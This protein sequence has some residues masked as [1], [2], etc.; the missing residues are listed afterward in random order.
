[1]IMVKKTDS[2]GMKVL[3]FNLFL[4]LLLTTILS[5]FDLIS[6][7]NII[8]PHIQ[9]SALFLSLFLWIYFSFNIPGP[10]W[11]KRK[12]W[13]YVFP[14]VFVVLLFLLILYPY[15]S[16]EIDLVKLFILIFFFGLLSF[17]FHKE[18]ISTTLKHED[19]KEVHAQ[20]ELE[21][22][23]INKFRVLNDIPLIGYVIRKI[24][25]Q[26]FT[27][28]L[29]I[30][31]F[32]VYGSFLVLN[33]L[34]S[35]DIYHDEQWELQ[36][37]HSL[38]NG[39][40]FRLWNYITSSP[41][42]KINN[43]IILSSLS[44]M[45]TKLF[46]FNNFS[47]RLPSAIFGILNILLVFIAFRMYTNKRIG[48]ITSLGFLL[49]L[50]A[51]YLARFFRAYTIALFFYLLSFIFLSLFINELKNKKIRMSQSI[52][53]ITLGIVSLIISI[54]ER[55]L[56]K[57]LLIL[58][59]L[60]FL[61][62]ILTNLDMFRAR[63]GKTKL[64]FALGSLILLI[65]LLTRIEV[66]DI[67]LIM[68]QVSE[69]ISLSKLE[70]PTN[71]YYYYLFEKYIKSSF[72]FYFLVFVGFFFLSFDLLSKKCQSS[73][74]MIL[75]IFTVIPMIFMIY[76]LNRY[77]DPRYIYFLIPFVYSFFGSGL[78][79]LIV[80]F[81]PRRSDLFKSILILI[82]SLTF[83]FYLVLPMQDIPF[84]SLKS[85]S[86]WSGEEPREYWHH[87][88][89]VPEYTKA[90]SYLNNVQKS[91]DV[92]VII[93][94][95]YNLEVTPGVSYYNLNPWI[96]TKN[97]TSYEIYNLSSWDDLNTS[98]NGVDFFNIVDSH[99]NGSIYVLGSYLLMLDNSLTSYL[100]NNC[101]NKAQDLDIMK[102]DM[103][104]TQYDGRVYWP[105]LFICNRSY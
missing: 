52:I 87:R 15:V 29:L 78:D 96:F 94:G 30:L 65:F 44:Y 32:L 9:F 92:V 6:V 31:L 102:F 85:P 14:V 36:V 76:L 55:E 11:A 38:N 56:G 73:R 7:D 16:L 80:L 64:I 33:N 79:Y 82:I 93:D 49:N 47:L 90:Y 66:L 91:G 17:I 10:S 69:F 77:E 98:L 23:F 28:L 60:A 4:L 20:N 83:F 5:Y 25:S 37:I 1:M 68:K 22:A 48:L 103:W 19:L 41:M 72:A 46:G 57:I 89:V 99:Q 70:N 42:M 26:G 61:A 86:S 51:L 40:G 74:K 54:E 50:N 27:Y 101:T 95:A 88:A 105:N 67:S 13:L 100:I 71:I 12:L 35:A 3:F 21:N 84:T 97:I 59:P 8:T 75:L 81:L 104:S 39:E 2:Y 43:G 58:Y 34:G 45:S 63:V 62:F 18:Y 53:F 24:Y